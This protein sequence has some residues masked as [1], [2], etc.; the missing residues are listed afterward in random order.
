MSTTTNSKGKRTRVPSKS[1]RASPQREGSSKK[2][3]QTIFTKKDGQKYTF[4]VKKDVPQKDKIEEMIYE[5]GGEVV[6]GPTPGAYTLSDPSK[7]NLQTGQY[8]YRFIYD[9]VSARRMMNIEKYKVPTGGPKKGRTIF[10]KEEDAQILAYLIEQ[11]NAGNPLHGN[12]I[13]QNYPLLDDR[14]T[15]QSIRHRANK[16][17]IPLLPEEDEDEEDEEDEDEEI[18]SEH[19]DELQGSE[20]E[21]SDDSCPKSSVKQL[22]GEASPK[23]TSSRLHKNRSE[24][25]GD[26]GDQR[27]R[28]NENLQIRQQIIETED[29]ESE[30]ESVYY[31]ST[32]KI[33]VGKSPEAR[34]STPR[35]HST[36]EKESVVSSK[37]SS[38]VIR[39]AL[40]PNKKTLTSQDSTNFESKLRSSSRIASKLAQN[41]AKSTPVL[42]PS[43]PASTSLA[44]N[45][46]V[47]PVLSPSTPASTSLAKESSIRKRSLDVEKEPRISPRTSS[48][49]VETK[50]DL[51]ALPSTS[52]YSSKLEVS[53]L[54][55][56]RTSLPTDEESNKMFWNPNHNKTLA[57]SYTHN[58]DIEINHNDNKSED[59]TSNIDIENDQDLDIH[60][61][62]SNIEEDDD[63]E[64]PRDFLRFNDE[65][66][67]EFPQSPLIP[68]NSESH[69]IPLLS[70]PATGKTIEDPLSSNTTIINFETPISSTSAIKEA[71][72]RMT[73]PS[74]SKRAL[75]KRPTSS[76]QVDHP[77]HSVN[78]T[79]RARLEMSPSSIKLFDMSELEEPP[80]SSNIAHSEISKIGAATPIVS[81]PTPLDLFTQD[82][83]Q[84]ALDHDVAP[85]EVVK[86]VHETGGRLPIV[87]DVVINGKNASTERFFWTQEEDEQLKSGSTVE[88]LREI[89]QKHGKE[90][91][92]ERLLYLSRFSETKS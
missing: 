44:N 28:K 85:I 80:T 19:V 43:T 84:L 15:W 54:D 49:F 27:E 60:A 3:D 83:F 46:K 66:T 74:P 42:S 24:E 37:I 86:M 8:D 53:K 9:S 16:H 56:P 41:N 55:R 12:I 18:E 70:T 73:T 20:I 51:T 52:N 7:Q 90:L 78:R 71:S 81:A 88:S 57:D 67:G 33:E 48:R 69:Q 92:A 91:F 1:I 17:I 58:D 36:V 26:D 11:R 45:V 68:N 34:G 76:I 65:Y 50:S 87:R 61:Q 59:N 77:D 6:Q 30:D 82:V 13:Y 39:P 72:S 21:T 62:D 4:Y 22:T 64:T 63:D 32:I 2:T 31:T 75:G 23:K 25:D 79:K 35:R 5:G 14:H 89:E 47:T 40:S 38:S 10:T 29:K